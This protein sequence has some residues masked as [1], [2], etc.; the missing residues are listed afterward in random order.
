M[1]LILARNR[2]GFS[3][4]GLSQLVDGL[5]LRDDLRGGQAILL[6]GLRVGQ[7]PLVESLDSGLKFIKTIC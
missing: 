5:L 2:R 1:Q 3:S 6:H 4:A 7:G